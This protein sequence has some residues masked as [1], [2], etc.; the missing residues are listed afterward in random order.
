MALSKAARRKLG[1]LA[2]H[3]DNSVAEMIRQRGGNAANVRQAGPWATKTLGETAEAA[4]Q[5]DSAAATAIKIVK[6]AGR[7]G[8]EH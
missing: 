6:Q 7:L 3:E 5:G 4:V 2:N 1:N 8:E